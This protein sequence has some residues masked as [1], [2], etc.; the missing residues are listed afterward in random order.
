MRSR[1]FDSLRS[2]RAFSLSVAARS[3]PSARRRRDE[4][5]SNGGGGGTAALG[6]SL[7]GASYKNL[8]TEERDRCRTKR[9]SGS[10]AR[11]V[12]I[13][14]SLRS[15]GGW[16]VSRCGGAGPDGIGTQGSRCKR[17]VRE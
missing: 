7:A 14:R 10:A 11:G 5:E 9:S 8:Y 3:E 6:S 15:H 17:S 2:L 4:G 13:G 12:T 1:P 16:P